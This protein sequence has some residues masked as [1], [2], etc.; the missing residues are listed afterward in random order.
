M[1]AGNVGLVLASWSPYLRDIPFRVAVQMAYT[2]RDEDSPP[3]Y[4][5]GWALL[6]TAA[7]ADYGNLCGSEA[8]GQPRCRG[9][10][11]C[12]AARMTVTRAVK[13]LVDAGF[14]TVVVRPRPGKQAEYA[15]QLFSVPRSEP[16]R[17]SERQ[18]EALAE[19][20][21]TRQRTTSDVV[22][23]GVT[24]ADV[25]ANSAE[26]HHVQRGADAPRPTL[27]IGHVQRG[28]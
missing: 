7:G 26:M 1:G 9:C 28:A 2:S 19:G 3:R 8:P 25:R 15:L 11:S 21:R 24:S 10:A 13:Q 12:K 17:P 14:C 18:R 27:G 23:H 4:W 5:G 6:A 20:G 16:R 22:R